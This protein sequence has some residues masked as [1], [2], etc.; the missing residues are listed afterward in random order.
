MRKLTAYFIRYPI[1]G[2]TILLFVFIFGF[3][4]L[5]GMKTSFFAPIDPRQITIQAAYPGASPEEVEEGIVLKI[6]ERLKGIAGIE[7]TTSVSRENSASVAIE[8]KKGYDSDE[9][10]T[11]VKNAVDS[12]SSFP[13]D[14]EELTI[15]NEDI[16]DRAIQF[17]L[18]GPVPLQTLKQY[19][20]QIERD[21][22]NVEGISLIT[23]QGYP[24]EEIVILVNEV[25]LR[26]YGLTFAEVADV[27]RQANQD[28][29]GGLIKTD[30]EELV[31]RSRS[32]T[33]DVHQLEQIV[34]RQAADGR[35]V[36][37]ADIA[38]VRRDWA[39]NPSRSFV[40]GNPAVQVIVN[41]TMEEDILFVTNY[42]K[43]YLT[44]FNERDIPVKATIINDGS[45]VLK[46]RIQLL[47]SNG[48]MGFFLVVFVLTFFLSFRLA[49]WVAFG[50]PVSFMGLFI[51]GYL[52]GMT[53]NIISLFGM[54][55]VVGILVDDG[56][57]IS[58]NIF[59]RFQKGEPPLQAALNGV[60]EVLPSVFSA[61]LTTI[62]AFTPFYFLEGR[63]ADVMNNMATVVIITLAV[64][65]V[66]A[67]FILPAHLVHS[68]S[69][70]EANREVRPNFLER[71]G[72]SILMFLRHRLYEPV[73]D[74]GLH[75]RF[76]IFVIPVVLF[77]L[78]LGAIRGG[79]IKTTFFPFIDQDS[80][81]ISVIYPAG[82]REH[83]T[84]QT[85]DYMEQRIWQANEFF[86]SRREDGLPVITRVVKTL[87]GA[88]QGTLSVELLDGETRNME[89]FVITQKIRELVGNVPGVEK[90][91]YGGRSFFGKPISV[92]LLG[93][94]LDE[95][96][97]VAARLKTALSGM[98]KL[99]D[100]IDN[101]DRGLREVTLELKDKAR[102]LG[103]TEQEMISQIRNGFFGAEVQR[104]QIGDE[105]VRIWVRYTQSDRS[106]LTDLETM[107][108]RFP[109]GSVYPVAA[110][111][112]FH[113]YRGVSAINHVDGFREIRVEADLANQREPVP[114]IY[115]QIESTILPPILKEFPSVR[116]SFE[117]QRRETDKTVRSAKVVIPIMMFTIFAIIALG[118]RSFGQTVIVLLLLP[119]AFIGVAW[120]HFIHQMP[121]SLMSVYGIIALIG[122]TVNNAIVFVNTYNG[123]L[124]QGMKLKEA[125]LEAGLSRFRPILLTSFT[126]IAGLGPLILERSRQAK[127]LIPMAISVAYGL[128]VVTIIILV[129]LPVLLVIKNR[130]HVLVHQVVFGRRPEPE[131]V[132]PAVT[133]DLHKIEEK[134]DGAEK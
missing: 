3:F 34:V 107:R 74:F 56:I 95:L 128:A 131:E 94:D 87:Q 53:I 84:L 58:E 91:T 102:M 124:K 31:I 77:F 12:I 52:M 33:E 67:V 63:I 10:L 26:A 47:T 40:N 106:S 6:E 117:G 24:A 125:L 99:K 27:V 49:F 54:I 88:S 7:R 79:L 89:S 44:A 72:N 105:E 119:F 101:N 23:I 13:L 108:I 41:K 57:V 21:L 29:S 92:S 114:P 1:W 118:F 71:T 25:T 62:I 48:L 30:Q 18:S 4:A 11:D 111:A 22:R 116:I 121:I 20:K 14:M 129:L 59:R 103:V 45:V 17:S 93:N 85:L 100:V 130:G 39:D 123:F 43:N 83:I 50:I 55:V 86:Q 36:R 96:A 98:D 51:V 78:T 37:L 81:S 2:N 126:T 38:E 66:E 97:G 15:V 68:K 73:L 28:V 122:I 60:M 113:I 61:I 109:D 104:L 64:S 127:F 82:T 70:Q 16:I 90:L 5:R 120:G 69:L 8:V 46:Q 42:V 110:L 65:L 32:K 35:L 9:V 133:E 115:E 80:V 76:L 112:T 19:A 134:S 132:E 75:H